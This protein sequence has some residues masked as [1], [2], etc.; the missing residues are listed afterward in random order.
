MLLAKNRKLWVLCLLISFLIACQPE[1]SQPTAVFPAQLAT[2]WFDL[3][4]KLTQETPG[5]TPPV[6]SRA[7]GYSGVTLY[8]SVVAGM[9]Q[10]NSLVG[11]LNGL[12]SLPQPEEGEVYH[13]PTAA[14]SALAAMLRYLY[15]TASPANRAAI[16]A[17]EGKYAAQ[18]KGEVA[19]DVY[20]RSAAYGKS[21]AKAIFEWSKSDGGHQGYAANFPDSY[22]PPSGNG[23]W[24]TTPPG[25]Q[26]ALQPYW[27]HNRPFVLN[28]QE[29]CVAPPPTEYSETA[30]SP[31]YAEAMEVYTAVQNLTPEQEAIALFWADD[32]GKTVTPPGHSISIASI[33]LRQEEADL[34]A[35]AEIYARVGI[36]VAD[37]FIGC[38]NAKFTYNLVRP[39][40]Y[41]QNIINP[42][43]NT[44]DITD[45]V[46]TPPFPE[47]TSGHS[48]QSGATATVLTAL[49]GDNYHFTDDTHSQ[50]GLAARTYNSFYEAADEAAISRLYGGIHYRPAI[51]MGMNQ[52]RCI[53]EL[54]NGLAWK[55]NADG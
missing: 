47:Y 9:P 26:I 38:W 52:G 31:F 7:L 44:P 54:V 12:D 24:V 40:S 11:Q 30:D 41:I 16:N 32:P 20:G 14:N 25:Y 34:A 10:N 49:F 1:T 4:L 46:T 28:P 51:E 6:A 45:P 39:I 21:V 5:F 22:L 3:Q 29:E 50:R 23:L 2:E 43:W 33:V 35:A 55:L 13:W 36:A 15:P 37:A 27:H 19:E 53:G 48:V 8:E 42:N 18:Y 17:L